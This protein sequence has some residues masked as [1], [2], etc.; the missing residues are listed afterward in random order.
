MPIP[1]LIEE[2]LS[3]LDGALQALI[4]RSEAGM[5]MLIDQAGFLITQAGEASQYDT[6]TLAA[7]AA[8]SYAATQGMASLTQDTNFNSV[9]QQGDKSSLLIIGMKEHCLLVVVF[10]STISVGA[11]KY[12]AA[13][14]VTQVNIQ[15]QKA[16]ARNPDRS[17]DLAAL[18]LEDTSTVFH[19]KKVDVN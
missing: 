6:T 2:D 5:A 13:N 8:G 16:R 1:Q 18:N 11:V 12:Y 17:L 7:L 4:K 9:Y 3:V 10:N 15:L 14:T 19:R